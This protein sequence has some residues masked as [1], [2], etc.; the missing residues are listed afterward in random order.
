LEVLRTHVVLSWED[1][2]HF[3]LVAPQPL[4]CI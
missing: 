2:F 1:L 3:E 4:V